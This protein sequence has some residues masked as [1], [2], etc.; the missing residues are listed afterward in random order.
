[1]AK[2]IS[3]LTFLTLVAHN[4]FAPNAASVE[5]AS[6]RMLL[7]LVLAFSLLPVVREWLESALEEALD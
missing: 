7:A 1:M 3:A 6:F 2:T 4:F 5:A